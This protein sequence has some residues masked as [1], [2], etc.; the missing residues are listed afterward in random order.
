[1]RSRYATLP[2]IMV[3]LYYDGFWSVLVGR[4]SLTAIR[5]LNRIHEQKNGASVDV[6]CLTVTFGPA[7]GG[8]GVA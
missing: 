3:V 1:M 8:A 2:G 4:E 6:G 5:A 7:P